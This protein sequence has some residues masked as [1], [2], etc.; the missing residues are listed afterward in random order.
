MRKRPAQNGH[1]RHYQFPIVVVRENQQCWAYVP[2]LP[3]VYG[4]GK[5][6]AQAKRDIGA[7]L[8]LYIDDCIAA[9]DKIPES[10]AKVVT[11][12]TLSVAVGD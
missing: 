6:P 7:A 4:R 2:D 1:Q 10:T 5:T 3:G 11:V 9:G 12:D 8:K